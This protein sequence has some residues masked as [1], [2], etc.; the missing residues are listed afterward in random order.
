MCHDWKIHAHLGHTMQFVISHNI[1]P[2]INITTDK[3]IIVLLCGH[4]WAL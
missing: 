1:K 2:N 4:L 3:I